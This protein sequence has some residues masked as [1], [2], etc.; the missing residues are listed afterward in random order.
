MWHQG[1]A[2]ECGLGHHVAMSLGQVP[3]GQQ[4]PAKCCRAGD[5]P[6]DPRA[7]PGGSAQQR[8]CPLW[9]QPGTHQ[10]VRRPQG[11]QRRHRAA[12]GL[13]WLLLF[14]DVARAVPPVTPHQPP[15]PLSSNEEAKGQTQVQQ[16]RRR[17]FTT[18]RGTCTLPGAAALWTRR[19]A[20]GSTGLDG[21]RTPRGLSRLWLPGL[22]GKVG[23]LE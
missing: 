4:A 20:T 12:G 13:C 9:G 7:A 6:S 21:A 14:E 11:A 10:A 18:H 22:G 3:P 16:P 8:V 17:T 2:S 15:T 19:R 5:L 1:T 23:D